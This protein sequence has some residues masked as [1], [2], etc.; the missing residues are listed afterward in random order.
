MTLPIDRDA[1]FWK[2]DK[3]SFVFEILALDNGK[4]RYAVYWANEDYVPHC[5]KCGSRRTRVGII[6]INKYNEEQ[7]V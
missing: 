7:V 3:C 1:F 4:P 5:P 6:N 2:C